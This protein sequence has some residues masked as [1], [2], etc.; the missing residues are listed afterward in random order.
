MKVS[1][2]LILLLETV[3]YNDV[4]PFLRSC[5]WVW[6]FNIGFVLIYY[7]INKLI[8]SLLVDLIL[9]LRLTTFS[10]NT[11]Q[12]LRMNL[13]DWLWIPQFRFFF[14]HIDEYGS[15]LNWRC[16]WFF[17]ILRYFKWVTWFSSLEPKKYIKM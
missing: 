11:F 13:F 7:S 14:L 1:K 16:D 12:Y 5:L 4:S 3:D 8:F 15:S 17:W 10:L 6:H 9:V 2:Q